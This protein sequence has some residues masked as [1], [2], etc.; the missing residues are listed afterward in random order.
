VLDDDRERVP[1][2]QVGQVL[3]LVVDEATRRVGDR[4]VVGREAGAT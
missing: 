4:V 2:G 3:L 1:P